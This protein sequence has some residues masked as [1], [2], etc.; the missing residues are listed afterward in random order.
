MKKSPVWRL[1]QPLSL[2][3]ANG[4]QQFSVS[5][6]GSFHATVAVLENSTVH[7]P[8]ADAAAVLQHGGHVGQNGVG[9]RPCA[10]LA[11][12]QLL[13]RP[14]VA[15]QRP[16]QKLRLALFAPQPRNHLCT[17]WQYP[18]ECPYGGSLTYQE[19]REE[20][21]VDDGILKVKD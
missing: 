2:L 15:H 8:G 7:T 4:K 10:G 5:A 17:Q 16:Q 12:E 13:A 21:C 14:P 9:L 1:S 18:T 3:H 11:R 6:S 19:N 20:R